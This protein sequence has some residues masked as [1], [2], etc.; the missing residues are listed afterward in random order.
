MRDL[1]PGSQ[2]IGSMMPAVTLLALAFISSAGLAWA[3][4]PVQPAPKIA[5]I[6]AAQAGR[7][8]KEIQA[9]SD[10]DGGKMWGKTLYGATL[11]VDE[12]TRDVVADRPDYQN[13]LKPQGEV[14]V[15]ALPL[16]E[17]AANTSKRWGGVDW[18]MVLWPLPDT[19]FERDKLVIH[20]SFH[21]IQD[22]LGLGGPDTANDH[23]DTEEGRLWLQLEWRAL[24]TAL[25]QQKAAR[26]EGR[27]GRPGFPRLPP[28][29]VQGRG[30]PRADPGNARGTSRIYGNRPVR[31]EPRRSGGVRRRPIGRRRIHGHLRAL[32]R[33]HERARL[34]DS[35]G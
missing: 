4:Q 33:L 13:L 29:P 5:S 19:A 30:G 18:T 20:E 23:L 8:F 24:R 22:D 28:V 14:F 27:A 7:M 34:R 9:L 25:L 35:P 3:G 21:R 32:L 31:T 12:T 17:N 16:D 26:K 6:D 1:R 11:F 15:G 2:K 10:K